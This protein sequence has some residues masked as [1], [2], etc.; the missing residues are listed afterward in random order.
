[1]KAKQPTGYGYVSTDQSNELFA[2]LERFGSHDQQ[3]AILL[4][5]LI[6]FAKITSTDKD[7]VHADITANWSRIPAPELAMFHLTYPY[8]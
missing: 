8:P 5:T 6:G 1:M 4:G 7:Q 3:Y 2:F